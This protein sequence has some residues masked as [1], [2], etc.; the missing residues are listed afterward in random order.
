[1][2]RKRNGSV[3]CG[4]CRYRPRGGY[5]CGHPATQH[6]VYRRVWGVDD[7]WKLVSNT[8]ELTECSKQN[9]NGRCIY[10]IPRGDDD[11]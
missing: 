7:G 11:E 9:N 10:F 5:C 8:T 1:M 2:F 4:E 6:K 3:V